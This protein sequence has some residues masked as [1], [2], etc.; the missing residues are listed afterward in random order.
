LD[1]N[2]VAGTLA[3]AFGQDM[4]SA[5]A[6][7]AGCGSSGPL[8]EARAYLGAGTVLRCSRCDAVLLAFVD[9]GDVLGVDGQGVA[10]LAL[11]N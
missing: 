7:C 11:P 4:T 2:A 9:H 1:G 8:A 10:A 5:I 3:T 6:R